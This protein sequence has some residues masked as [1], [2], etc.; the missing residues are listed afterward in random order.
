MRVRKNRTVRYT[1]DGRKNIKAGYSVPSDKSPT[2]VRPVSTDYFVLV[3]PESGEM[4]FEELVALYGNKP[5]LLYVTFPSD[6]MIDF[7]NDDYKQWGK[8][9]VKIKQCDG[10]NVEFFFD[11]TIKGMKYN[12]GCEYQCACKQHGLFDTEDKELKK[13]ACKCD[14]YLKVQ[15]LNPN[16]LL[17]TNLAPDDRIKPVS[18]LCYIVES[19]ST[20]TADNI[21]SE[22]ERYRKLSGYPFVLTIKKVKGNNLSYPLISLAPFITPDM[23]IDYNMKME[24]IALQGGTKQLENNQ[25]VL[26]DS[27][28]DTKFNVVIAPKPVSNST[29][30]TVL[31]EKVKETPVVTNQPKV[32]K[33]QVLEKNAK[34]V[35]GTNIFE[36]P[37]DLVEQYKKQLTGCMTMKAYNEV[38]TAMDKD[39]RLTKDE[40]TLLNTEASSILTL[41]QSAT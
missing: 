17:D 18:P 41:I 14:M 31:V 7:F 3:H 36:L 25:Q 20:N 35:P 21:Y 15:I 4:Y 22:L 27:K 28:A 2:G 23:L 10:E 13:F 12:A 26:T 5:Q 19:H 9:S 33:E 11:T 39:D 37:V 1:T 34:N 8:N 30:K 16:M 29:G 40:R 6:N 24:S 38:T 32:T